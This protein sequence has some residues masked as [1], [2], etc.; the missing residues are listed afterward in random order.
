MFA[1]RGPTKHLRKDFQQSFPKT[2][3][4]EGTLPKTFCLTITSLIII[5]DKDIIGK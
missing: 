4:E 1:Q 5:P 3:E 2:M